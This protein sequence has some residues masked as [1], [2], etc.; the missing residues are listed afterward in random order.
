M[1][2]NL[3][4]QACRLLH[5][6][7]KSLQHYRSLIPA[8]VPSALSH[9]CS[10][11]ICFSA[12][13]G[14][15]RRTPTCCCAEMVGK[16]RVLLGAEMAALVGE[17]YERAYGGMVR[18]Q[19]LTELEEAVDYAMALTLSNGE[20]HGPCCLQGLFNKLPCCVHGCIALLA[21]SCAR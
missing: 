12:H 4:W 1:P 2:G 13:V 9:I 15:L 7:G 21:G 19:Q 14:C 20:P 16:A 18:A 8:R 6:T 3:P 17:S 10:I 11:G 5:G